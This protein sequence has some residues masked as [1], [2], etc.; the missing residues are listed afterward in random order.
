MSRIRGCILVLVCVGVVAV[1]SRAQADA[2][3]PANFSVTQAGTGFTFNGH[4]TQDNDFALIGFSVDFQSLLNVAI[5]TFN[6][7]DNGFNPNLFL[8]NPDGSQAVG[9]D[10]DGNTIDVNDQDAGNIPLVATIAAGNYVLA[11]SQQLN[12]PNIT[13]PG[14]SQDDFPFYTCDFLPEPAACSGFIDPFSSNFPAPRSNVIAGSAT[15]TSLEQPA[16]VPEP[17]TLILLATGF[18]YGAMRRGFRRGPRE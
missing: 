12:F 15:I 5:T 11:I 2:I 3:D 16:P 6:D 9:L 18:G 8:L 10:A 14:F 17:A 13:S 4:F 1:P 7:V